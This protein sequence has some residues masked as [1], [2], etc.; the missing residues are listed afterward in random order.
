MTEA[1][2]EVELGAAEEE[3]NTEAA[4]QGPG[5]ST[6][7]TSK[8]GAAPTA[9]AV[10]LEVHLDFQLSTRQQLHFLRSPECLEDLP[11][12]HLPYH[13][14]LCPNRSTVPAISKFI[15]NNW[16]QQPCWLAGF[17]RDTITGHNTSHFAWEIMRCISTPICLRSNQ[18]TMTYSWTHFDRIT[19][20]MSIILK[21]AWKLPSSN[22]NRKSPTFFAIYKLQHVALTAPAHT[23]LTGLSWRVS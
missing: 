6:K 12:Q 11:V 1:E 20:Q 2:S 19:L 21:H 7:S 23:W 18:T 3:S 17:H 15:S 10:L 5:I 16:L 13:H 4:P 14:V 9:P 8:P 22:P